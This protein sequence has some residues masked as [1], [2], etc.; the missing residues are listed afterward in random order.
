VHVIARLVARARSEGGQTLVEMLTAL[1][2]GSVVLFGVVTVF[3]T[4][5]TNSAKVTDRVDAVQ[6]ARLALDRMQTLLDSQVCLSAS[7]PPIVPGSASTAT[8]VTF[9]AD[10]GDETFTPGQYRLAYDAGARTITESYWA[11]IVNGGVTTFATNPT[12]SKVIATD[13]VPQDAAT[14][15]FRYFAYTDPPAPTPTAEQTLPLG[16]GEAADIVRVQANVLVQPSRTKRSDPTSASLSADGYVATADPTD[17][18]GGP[19]C[20]G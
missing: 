8:Q 3:T 4:A 17:P 13:V 19:R 15:M 12:T 20:N 11:P 10:L 18:T 16:A 1:T 6:R 7:Q 9:Y 2:I 14:P 5:L